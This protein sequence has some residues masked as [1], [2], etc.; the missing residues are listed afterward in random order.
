MDIKTALSELSSWVEKY[1]KGFSSD[2]PD[3]QKNI[4]LKK[5]HTFRV[6]DAISDIGKSINLNINDMCIAEAC[7]ILHDI[8]RFEQHR[9]Y[10]TFSDSL[11]E[12]HAALG[13]RIIRERNVLKNFPPLARE[14]IIRSVGCHNMSF[15]PN[16]NKDW[17]L[18]LKL[19]RDADKIDILYVVT[20]YYKN[21]ASG[22]NKALELHLPDI[23]I[24]SDAV[25]KSLAN[26]KI[27]LLK[28]LRSL[29]DFKLYQMGW[30]YDLNF[31][32][33]LRIIEERGYLEKIRD[34]FRESSKKAE[35]IYK[36]VKA[37]LERRVCDPCLGMKTRHN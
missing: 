30:V 2:D 26:G 7:A 21:N 31:S 32:R 19:L 25:Y 10:G 1:I 29:N 6:K 9:K 4:D 33:S 11:S 18:F 14:V 27:A 12:N 22:S 13:V 28:D 34:S 8:G 3:V 37:F 23:D 20:D 35:E 5:N 24:I 15:I 36:I 17:I 16:N